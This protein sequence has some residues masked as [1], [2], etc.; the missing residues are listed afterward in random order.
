[1]ILIIDK[2][3]KIATSLSDAFFNMGILA[4]GCTPNEALSE[5]SE[6]YR[7]A[8]ITS[9]NSLADIRDFTERMRRYASG[10]P[11]FAVA[12]EEEKQEYS[13]LFASVFIKG[14]YASRIAEGVI[15]YTE[16]NGLPTPA[17]YTLAGIDASA[18]LSTPTYFWTALPFTKTET[19]IL[20]FLIRSYPNPISADKI[21]EYAY[22][23]SRVPDIANI[24]THISVMNKKFRM[25]TGRNIIEPVFNAGYRLITP[26]FAEASGKR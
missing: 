23:P 17:R 2:Q 13:P 3:K 18:D 15:K 25:I 5:I 24:R 9:P 26:E 10:V 11:L 1:M 4:R 16:E 6:I 12:T 22:R 19:M 8:V 14:S 21:L 20:R 7:A